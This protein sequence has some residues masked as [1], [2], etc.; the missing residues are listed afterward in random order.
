MS[1]RTNFV[2]PSGVSDQTSCRESNE[3]AG[4]RIRGREMRAK[5]YGLIAGGI[6]LEL[7]A[8]GWFFGFPKLF[9]H[10]SLFGANL[11]IALSFAAAIGGVILIG[12]AAQRSRS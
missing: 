2:C 3:H 12:V 4:P 5:P 8:A 10:P 6:L 7:I 11:W 9:P 1:N